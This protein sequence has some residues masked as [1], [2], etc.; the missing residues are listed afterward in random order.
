MKRTYFL[1]GFA[2]FAAATFA[3]LPVRAEASTA[4]E[5]GAGFVISPDYGDLLEDVYEDADST[6]IGGWLDLHVGVRMA[7]SDQLTVTPAL[8]VLLNYVIVDGLGDEDE[9]YLNS[10]VIPSVGVRYAFQQ[11]PS[12][13]LGGEINYNTPNSGSDFYEFDSGGMGWGAF[14]GYAFDAMRM[15]L[16]YLDIPVEVGASEEN[17]GGVMFRIGFTL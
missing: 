9:T 4:L 7:L 1:A 8:D 2:F 16:G 17:L 13:Y 10:I 3:A 11:V 12:L 14:V 6:G 15:E 5:L